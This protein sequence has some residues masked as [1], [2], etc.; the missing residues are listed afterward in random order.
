MGSATTDHERKAIEHAVP[1]QIE[2]PFPAS[3]LDERPSS[4]LKEGEH[5]GNDRLGGC[6]DVVAIRPHRN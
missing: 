2:I 5:L 3:A 1:A 4:D 6:F